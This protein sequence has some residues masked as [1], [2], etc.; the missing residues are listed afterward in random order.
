MIPISNNDSKQHNVYFLTG[1]LGCIGA[2]VIKHI[3][4]RGDTAVVYDLTDDTRRIEEVCGDDDA[5]ADDNGGAAEDCGTTQKTMF[6]G[7]V[8]FVLGDIT[9]LESLKAA[10]KEC[11]PKAMIH[12]AALQIPFC[13]ADPILGANVNVLGMIHVLEAA[14]ACKESVER[15]CYASS[16]AVFG[17]DD[18]GVTAAPDETSNCTPSTL[19]GVFKLANEGIARVYYNEQGLSSV[20]L[21]PLTVYGVG[22]DQGLTSGPTTAMKAA[23]LG[24]Q[25]SIAFGGKT[26]FQHVSDVAAIFVR[27]ADG[28]SSG[29]NDATDPPPPEGAKVYNI[30][31]E[32]V[33]VDEIIQTIE[34]ICPDAVG[35]ITSH[36]PDLPIPPSLNGEAIHVDYPGLPHTSLK[37]GIAA[38]MKRFEQL[39]AMGKLD[40]R[41]IPDD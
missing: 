27:C 3:V 39:H 10:V 41:D 35:K 1:A 40:T 36:G 15:V 9:N 30:H 20:G 4:D 14:L 28:V 38:T 29:S 16:A 37:E 13:R 22:R 32:T 26:D 34:G 25:Y 7:K 12:L 6:Q 33:G 11:K 2:S 5:N 21:R 23:V 17:A 8:K 31:G 18:G 24:R 19:Y